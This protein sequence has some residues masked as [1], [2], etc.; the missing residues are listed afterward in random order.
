MRPGDDERGTSSSRA[1]R[2]R[3]PESETFASRLGR[4]LD[5]LLTFLA[6]AWTVVV[7]AELTLELTPR[8]RGFLADVDA[9]IWLTFAVAFFVQFALAPDKLTYLRT[10][11]VTAIAVLIPAARIVQVAGAVTLLRPAWLA[12]LIVVG[13]RAIRETGELFREQR[14]LYVLALLGISTLL[15]ASGVYFFERHVPRSGFHDFG[16]AL[17]WAAAMA[18]TINTSTDPVTPEGRVIGFLLRVVALAFFGFVTGS[19]ASFLTVERIAPSAR[20]RREEVTAQLEED[21]AR[22]RD[23]ILRLEAELRRRDR[24]DRRE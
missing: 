24:T 7:I 13:D 1:P 14:L 10:H 19:I 2:R 9:A 18:T 12:H 20:V 11:V 15:S 8:A 3:A 21:I 16:D 5:P 4:L 17:W 6:F 23:Q 22:L